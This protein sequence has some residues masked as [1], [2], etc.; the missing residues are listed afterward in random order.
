M[1]ARRTSHGGT[2]GKM[3][4]QAIAAAEKRLDQKKEDLPDF[5]K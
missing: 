4:A 3:V 5:H 2:A 1:I